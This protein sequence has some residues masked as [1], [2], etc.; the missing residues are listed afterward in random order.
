MYNQLKEI[1]L[2]FVPV[3]L[4]VAFNLCYLDPKN[5]LSMI[6]CSRMHH[7]SD[8]TLIHLNQDQYTFAKL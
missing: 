1:L 6:S 2:D 3:H 4:G 7:K 5:Y 8:K